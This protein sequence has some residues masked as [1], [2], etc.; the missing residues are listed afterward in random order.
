MTA[1]ETIEVWKTLAFSLIPSVLLLIAAIMIIRKVRNW[2][3]TVLVIAAILYLV[4]PVGAQ[5]ISI[6]RQSLINEAKGTAAT[7]NAL[8][9]KEQQQAAIERETPRLKEIE[10]SLKQ[11][12]IYLKWLNDSR[13]IAMLAY[14]VML[15]IA[16]GMF[17][18]K[19]TAPKSISI[20]AEP[21]KD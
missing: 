9:T 13:Y 18:P 20:G 6:G 8:P 3:T 19:A 2:Y 11:S 7:I 15:M 5:T 4:L 1:A 21:A 14:G 12:E 16:I 10:A 17:E